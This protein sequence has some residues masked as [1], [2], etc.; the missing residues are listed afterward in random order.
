M[1]ENNVLFH[2]FTDADFAWKRDGQEYKFAAGSVTPMTDK[3]FNHFAKHLVDQELN[4]QKIR[5]NDEAKRAEFLQKCRAGAYTLPNIVSNSD[6]QIPSTQVIADEV[7]TEK[8][9]CEFCES[10][11]GRHLKSCTRPQEEAFADAK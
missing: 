1:I 11:G 2:N 4:R 6:L 8:R 3:E 10:K 5:T 7:P 9:F